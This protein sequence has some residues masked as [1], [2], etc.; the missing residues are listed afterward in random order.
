MEENFGFEIDG[1]LSDEEA[2]KFFEQEEAAVDTDKQPDKH[3][4]TEESAEEEAEAQPEQPSEKVGD[5]KETGTDA[6]EQ[7][8]GGSSSSL[9]SSI[10]SAL[11]NDGSLPGFDDVEPA[12]VNT[13]EDFAELMQKAVTS[14]MDERMRRIDEALNNG[15]QPESI[16]K[17]EKTLEYL[18]SLDDDALTAE[19]EDGENLR[20]YL[21]Y[22]DLITRGYTD[23]RAKREVE[24]SFKSASDIE[25]AK[26]A[27]DALKKHFND[28]YEQER[29]D[30]KKK[31]DESKARMKKQ[32]EDLRKMVLD[33]EIKLG[34]TKLDKKTCNRVYDA[35][36]KPVYK[37]PDTG[38]LMTAI[39]KFQKENPLE[40]LK[41]LGI[42]FVLTNGGKDLAGFVK[43]QVQ[44]QKR[45]GIRE[46]EKKINASSFNADGSI[47]YLSGGGRGTNEDVLLSDDW[48]VG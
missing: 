41:Q 16:Q 3:D 18:D 14:M 37:D 6:I 36:S 19:G 8:D 29:N 10:A 13:P 27:L 11:K 28:R 32:E 7:H 4:E 23:D 35:I 39:Q 2:E 9:Y 20:R 42:W 34:D 25:D 22:N 43:P 48:Q 44:A 38:R 47:N 31:A 46:L 33:D 30:A 21:I 15:V 1:I 24:K 5:E 26:D 45:N 40:F 17:Y 12:K